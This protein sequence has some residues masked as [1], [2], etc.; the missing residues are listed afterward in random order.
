MNRSPQKAIEKNKHRDDYHKIYG[1]DS[2]WDVFKFNFFKLLCVDLMS[3]AFLLMIITGMSAMVIIFWTLLISKTPISWL[4]YGIIIAPPTFF[5]LWWIEI[6]RAETL[7]DA[8][9][10]WIKGERGKK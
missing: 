6:Q 3:K 9:S 10:A 4:I 5:G 7:I 8:I 2:K 1:R